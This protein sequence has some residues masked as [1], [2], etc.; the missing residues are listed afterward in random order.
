M[1]RLFRIL[2]PD[3]HTVQ[4]NTVQYNTIQYNV[5]AYCQCYCEMFDGANSHIQGNHK[6]SSLKSQD[7]NSNSNSKEWG[8]TLLINTYMKD[9]TDIKLRI[10]HQTLPH[11]KVHL[12]KITMSY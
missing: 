4:Y 3:S 9:P 7:N 12:I 10:S 8:K 6:T 2:F 11:Y 1:E 5:I